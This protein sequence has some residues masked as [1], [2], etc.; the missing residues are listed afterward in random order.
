MHALLD[1]VLGLD[2]HAQKLDA[3]AQIVGGAKVLGRDRG[4]ALDV[5]HA[6]IDPGAEGETGEDRQL[7]RGVVTLDIEGRIGLGVAE[8]LGLF[9][10]ARERQ[11]LPL[12]AGQDVIA[13]AVEN[14]VDPRQRIADET[15]AQR[16]DDGDAAGHRCLE[17]QGDV[18]L[19]RQRRE[20]HAVPGEQ[21]LVGRDHRLAG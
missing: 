6:G 12:H 17:V 19:L 7:L 11:I 16:L 21:S 2:R 15:L 9:E 20:R 18:V 14:A 10:S 13:G 5:D 4:D 3:V 1:A 8:L